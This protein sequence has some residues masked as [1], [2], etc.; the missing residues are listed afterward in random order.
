MRSTKP[1]A[2]AS[3]A[4]L[5]VMSVL[6]VVSTAKLCRSAMWLPMNASHSALAW[7]RMSGL[8]PR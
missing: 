6:S 3:A 4:C 5:N 8:I 2:R 1:L 7:A